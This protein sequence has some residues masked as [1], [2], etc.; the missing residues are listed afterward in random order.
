MHNIS[1]LFYFVVALYMF[2]T[3]FPSIIRS[4]KTVHTASGICQTDSVDCL[5]VGTRWNLSSVSFPLASSQQNLFD[6]YL[7]LYVQSQTPDDGQKDR[8]MQSVTTKQNKFEKLVHLVGFAVQIY[9]D[10]DPINVKYIK[11]MLCS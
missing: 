7:M 6:I 2:R 9:H 1:N 4:L 10:I 11:W 5:L 8:N 3:V